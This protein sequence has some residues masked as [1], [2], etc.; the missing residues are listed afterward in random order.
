MYL[1]TTWNLTYKVSSLTKELQVWEGEGGLVVVDEPMYSLTIGIRHDWTPT[2]L[3][4]LNL[5]AMDEDEVLES[6]RSALKQKGFY[7]TVSV[8]KQDALALLRKQSN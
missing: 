4:V 7:M 3:Q 2:G 6:I 1:Y 8:W 5:T